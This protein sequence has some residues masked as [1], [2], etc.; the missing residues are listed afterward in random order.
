MRPLYL[1]MTAFG[2]YAAPTRLPFEELRQGLY[3]VTGDTGAGKTTLFDAISFALYGV[4]SGSERSPDMF[5]C[6][7][8]PK[9]TDTVV[10][11]RFSQGGREYTV[12]RSIHFNKKRG[13]GNQYGE[14][15]ISALLWEPERDV[16]EGA[17]K[18]TARMEALLGLNAEQFRKIIMLAQ[19]EF[20]EFLKADSDKKNEILGKLESAGRSAGFPARR[21][22]GA[23]RAPARSRAQ[24]PPP[25][26]GA[27]R[28]GGRPLSP[29]APGPHRKPA[30][31]QRG[32]SDGACAAA[33]RAG[34]L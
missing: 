22:P 2:S 25:A 31:S 12:E 7:R 3:L 23:A 17:T 19:G 18:V 27:F 29:R 10:R 26:R 34:G 5:H 16:L 9:S 24:H 13:G 30:G 33:C 15:R 14:A 21:T 11:L 6:D 20:R 32:G 8:V 28:G 1:E 4:A